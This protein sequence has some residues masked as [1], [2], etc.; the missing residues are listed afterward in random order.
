MHAGVY[1]FLKGKALPNNS[2]F[3]TDDEA[4]SGNINDNAINFP[5]CY[6]DKLNC[7]NVSREGGWSSPNNTINNKFTTT[8]S[9]QGTINLTYQDEGSPP[10]G[11]YCCTV[12]NA[13]N[14]NQTLC[15]NTG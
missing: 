8:W 2:Y 11:I 6:T 14:I 15:V 13:D 7:C 3:S 1:L 5:V 12:P 10:L 9:N 4:D